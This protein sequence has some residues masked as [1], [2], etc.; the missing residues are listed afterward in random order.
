MVFRDPDRLLGTARA[1]AEAGAR[2][3]MEYW[4]S[5]KPSQVDEKAKNDL[6]TD[7]DRASEAVILEVI[8]SAFPAHRYL[9][10]ESGRAEGGDEGQPMWIID[11]LDGTTN[12]V[13]GLPHFAV[14]VAAAVGGR[15]VVGVVLDPIKNDVFT[16]VQGGGTR[17]NGAPCRVSQ[18]QGL[19]GA[20]L[21]TG[22]P[23]RARHLLEPYLAIFH[24]VFLG[25]KAIRRP[26]AAALDLA[27]VAA[28]IFDGF[29][30]FQLSPWDIAAGALLVIEAGGVVSDMEGGDAYLATGDVVCGTPGVHGEML[31]IVRRHHGAWQTDGAGSSI[32]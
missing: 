3:L 29:F 22:F 20:L 6:V 13:H 10:E 1:A 12:F 17:W 31:E 9:A 30:E 2:T 24:D 15:P 23:F 4:R 21:T 5:L 18:R 32:L 14:S 7:A 16:A 11:P 8:R 28:G 19:A 26:G 27:Y 25:S